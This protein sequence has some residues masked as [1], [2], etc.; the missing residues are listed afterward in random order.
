ML[1]S[2]FFKLHILV[3]IQYALILN[4]MQITSN[5]TYGLKV[6]DKKKGAVK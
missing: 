4:N 3:E 1:C 5:E 6:I 2:L